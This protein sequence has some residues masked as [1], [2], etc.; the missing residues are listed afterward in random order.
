M[1]GTVTLEIHHA[2]Y[3]TFSHQRG[4]SL[5][6]EEGRLREL[7]VEADS[8]LDRKEGGFFEGI[9]NA[10][11]FGFER[12]QEN[13]GEEWTRGEMP[14][15]DLFVM[16]L[17]EAAQIPLPRLAKLLEECRVDSYT[18]EPEPEKT[19]K[20]ERR[21][22]GFS[23]P[24]DID[25]RF[26]ARVWEE[27]RRDSVKCRMPI[28]QFDQFVGSVR[29]ALPELSFVSPERR[30]TDYFDVIGEEAEQQ[31]EPDRR[32]VRTV[33]HLADRNA[34]S[35]DA[36]PTYRD[37][38]RSRRRL[39]RALVRDTDQLEDAVAEEF[40]AVRKETERA[41]DRYPLE[42][43]KLMEDIEKGRLRDEQEDDSGGIAGRVQNL[44]GGGDEKEEF[45]LLNPHEFSDIDP[46]VAAAIDEKLATRR[47]HIWEQV[48]EEL[49]TE[50]R[51]N[52]RAELDARSEEVAREAVRRIDRTRS[53]VAYEEATGSGT[54][55]GESGPR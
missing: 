52:L 38:L 14:Y 18:T 47:E 45:E 26:V 7:L 49:L 17:E 11:V 44:V 21:D 28:N 32:L 34:L 10:L 19:F 6:V 36:L 48:T 23:A 5:P 4:A 40:A 13:D 1:A 9:G 8:A 29:G 39:D 24:G 12:K 30:P 2:I 50:L 3:D 55:A 33:Q 43:A 53:T 37:E 35:I 22:T 41:F 15:F 51:Q 16:P 27:Y 31:A 42:A 46:E 54:G 20:I 25:A